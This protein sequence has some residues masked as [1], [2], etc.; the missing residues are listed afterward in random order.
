MSNRSS[1]FETPPSVTQTGAEAQQRLRGLAQLAFGSLTR[2][3]ASAR[4]QHLGLLPVET[5]E[6]DLDDPAQRQFGD[7]QLLEQIGEGGMGVV[8]R[9]RHI[10]LD[11]IVAIKLLSAG[12]WASPDF[13]TR[14]ERE[15]QNAARMQHP[16]IVTVFEVGNYEGLHFFSMRLV[17]GQSLSALL[18]HAEPFAPKAAATLMR[19]VAEAVAYAH[20]LGV[21]HL[22]LKPG[23][24]LI[25]AGGIAHVSDFG[26]ARRLENALAVASDEVSGTPAYM[27]PEQARVRTSRLTAVTDVWGLGAILYELIAG[28]PPFRAES[29]QAI[30]KLVQEGQVRAPRR[31]RPEVPLD[32]QAIA[33]RCLSREPKD[34][35]PSARALADDLARFVE[36]RPVQARP[37]NLLQ[38]SARWAR[39]EP[40]LAATALS[41]FGILA[42]GLI[43]TTQ[44]WRRADANARVA[45]TNAATASHRLWDSRNAESLRLME[46]GDGWKAAPLLLANLAEMEAQRD[47]VRVAAARKRLG[48]LANANPRL[49]DVWPVQKRSRGMALSADGTH[50]AVSSEENGIRLFDTVNGKEI[51]RIPNREGLAQ[52]AWMALDQLQFTPDGRTLLATGVSPSDTRVRPN[53]QGMLRLDVERGAWL[54]PPA[55]FADFLD[56]SYSADG[57]FATLTDK[58]QHVQFWSTDP[59]RSLSPLKPLPTSS[60]FVGKLIAPNGA[61][62]VLD[63]T[64]HAV[65]L[66]DATTLAVRAR[67]ELGDFGQIAAWAISADSRWLAMGDL[68]G[69]VRVVDCTTREVRTLQPHP[70]F[71]ARWITF[72]DDGAWLALAARAGGV[73]LWSWP[74]GR[75]LAPPFSGNPSA[76]GS[77]AAEHVVLDRKRNLVLTDDYS[78]STALWQVAPTSLEI[79]RADAAPVTSRINAR[80]EWRYTSVAWNAPQGLLATIAHD[81]LRLERLLPLALKSGRGARIKPG[82]L[83][84]DGGHLVVIE[85]QRVRIV[86]ARSERPIAGPFEFSQ[87]PDF[88]ELTSNGATLVAISGRMLHGFDV[89]TG[90]P[91]F[92]PVQLADSPANVDI[93]PDGKRIVVAWTAQLSKSDRTISEVAEIVDL[94]NGKRLGGPVELPGTANAMNFSDDGTRFLAWNRRDLMLRDGVTL[95]PVVGPMRNYRPRGI[96]EH[97]YDGYFRVAAVDPANGVQLVFGKRTNNEDH[98]DLR[99]YAVD[100]SLQSTPLPSSMTEGAEGILPLKDGRTVVLPIG[101]VD[102]S[103]FNA[104]GEIAALPDVADD[105]H[106]SVTA[107]SRD[108]RWLARGLRDGVA[109]FDLHDRSRITRLRVALPRPD[110]VWQLAFSPDGNGLL[111]RTLHNRYI[112]WN[113]EPDERPVAAIARE[114]ALRDLAMDVSLGGD[115]ARDP[116]A[117]ERAALR[118]HDPGAP[119]VTPPMAAV[120]AVRVLPGGAIPPRDPSTPVALLDLTPY[121]TF[122]LSEVFLPSAYPSGDY[123]WVPRGLQRLLGVDYDLRGGVRLEGTDRMRF[124]FEPIGSHAPATQQTS[125]MRIDAVDA[126]VLRDDSENDPHVAQVRL[127]YMGGTHAD[128]PLDFGKDT[129]TYWRQPGVDKVTPQAAFGRDARVLDAQFIPRSYVF[130]VRV[131]NPHPERPVKA[132]TVTRRPG[133]TFSPVVLALTLQLLRPIA[134]PT[135]T[136]Q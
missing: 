70:I 122:G 85:G 98:Y 67:I 30:L 8:Y 39:R 19:T 90:K 130:A 78:D 29:A 12:P 102:L 51:Q 15:A 59:W 49:V 119:F 35:Y 75:L 125:P 131:V 80:Y 32:L 17:E 81:R 61:F 89:V 84:F 105:T 37:L 11:R 34:R 86:D 92:A 57:R 76:G 64:E 69:N 56:A 83:R 77:P 42:V 106:Q 100:G 5:L 7:Y 103:V 33:L 36:G 13:I 127:D 136:R 82:T 94:A 73:Y 50:V 62:F 48:I 101:N 16:N 54:T 47:H 99:R 60:Q 109:L 43:A 21:L 112:V 3:D 53:A 121:Y 4:G 114:L 87:A 113:L 97:P 28:E 58:H 118:A 41:A 111:A 74:E 128:I 25:D 93:S 40:R 123:T 9:A 14:F 107:I 55:G 2:A 52:G 72:S 134:G 129:W 115:T 116:D 26:L 79:D 95:A 23:N 63:G 120:S 46:S 132:M 133:A 91:R 18:K 10:P 135:V 27:A 65:T 22:D 1:N 117:G 126:L 108:G 66:M 45:Q 71:G 44:Q 104:S 96:S 88:A 24:V 38:R 31:L 20:S 110:E 6:L 124:E 68:K